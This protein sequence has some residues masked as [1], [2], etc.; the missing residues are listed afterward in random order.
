MTQD[1]RVHYAYT[2]ALA[3]KAEKVPT[4]LHVFAAGGHGYGLG[5][6]AGGTAAWPALAVEW[7]K[8]TKGLEKK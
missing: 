1:D 4:E 2:Y 7:M 5:R 8:A 6:P 3:L